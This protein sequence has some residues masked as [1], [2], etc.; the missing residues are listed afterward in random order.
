[1]QKG[2]TLIE[3]LLVI[4]IIGILS[5][6][7]YPSYNEHLVKVHRTYAITA[8]MDLAGYMEEH[9][10]L[11]NTYKNAA[12]KND[13]DYK[14]YYHLDITKA[15]NNTYLLRATP[16]G[17]QAVTDTLCGTLTLNQD[18]IRNITGSGSIENCWH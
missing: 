1:M 4:A 11:N 16:L 17:K 15:D 8:L 6:I 10:A 14:N 7:A 13:A 9:H 12:T 18:G 5:S 3:I 2:F